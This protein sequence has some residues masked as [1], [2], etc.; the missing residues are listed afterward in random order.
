[1][2]PADVVATEMDDWLSP[3]R[4]AADRPGPV[5]A[6]NTPTPSLEPEPATPEPVAPVA[7]LA[8]RAV[9][10][11]PAPAPMAVVTQKPAAAPS[12][13]ANWFCYPRL[14]ISGPIVPYTD[15]SGGTDVGTAIRS[16]SCLS[17]YDLMGHA[18]TQFGLVRQW[19][20]GDIVFAWGKSFTVTGASTQQSCAAPLFPL[21]PLSMQT[22]LSSSTCG[23]VL[24][25][26]A[27]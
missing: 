4:A 3:M 25:V 7:T 11:T 2:G 14:G 12:C 5:T 20:A 8:P 24:V 16:Y 22:S 21:A 19:V 18:Y 15:C 17:D 6:S 26:Q 1:M 13:P 10:R 9:T 23:P 27:R